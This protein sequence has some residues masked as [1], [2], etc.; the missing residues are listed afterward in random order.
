LFYAVF[1]FLG[2]CTAV[3][4]KWESKSSAVC[5]ENIETTWWSI[6]TYS[7]AAFPFSQRFSSAGNY[8]WRT[9]QKQP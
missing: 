8:R 1:V 9:C 2:T 4:Y 3:V 7:P 5:S 6:C